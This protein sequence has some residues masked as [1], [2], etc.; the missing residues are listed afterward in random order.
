MLTAAVADAQT[1]GTKGDGK[2]FF[3]ETFGWENADD[4]KG[5]T[6]P[7][8]YF[9]LDPKDQGTNWQW[10][11]GPFVDLLTQDPALQSTTIENGCLALFMEPFNASSGNPEIKVDNS[12]VFP[13]LDCSDHSSVV[14]RYETHFMGSHPV[15][16]F[17]EVTVDDWV[18][19]ASYSVNFGCGH[20]DRP[21]DYPPGKAALMEVNISEIA[22]GMPNVQMR[23]HWMNSA[24]YYWAID[25]FTVSE[26]YD[27]DMKIGYLQM[28]WEEG[29]PDKNMAWIYNIPKSQLTGTNGFTNFQSAVLN[30]GEYDL[31]EVYMDLN[32]TKAGNSVFHRTSPPDD[33]FVLYTDTVRIEDLYSPV[34][35]GHYKVSVEFKSKFEDQNPSD[36]KRE[37]LFNVTDSIYSRADDTNELGWS[38]SKER[39]DTNADA[40]MGHFNGS[41]FPI[42]N[43][44]EV[45]SVSVF[46]AGGK[47]D[48]FINYRFS[49]YYVPLDEGD[50]TPF[51]ILTTETIQLD[52]ADFDTWVT[53]PFEKDGETEF[54]KQG[55]LVYAGITYDNTNPEPLV[56]RNRGLQIG[57]DNS[58]QLTESTAIAT[59]DGNWETG[60]GSFIGKK[61]LMIRLNLNDDSNIIDGIGAI[62]QLA[63]LGQNYPNPFSGNTRIDFELAG[64]AEVVVEV[65][66]ISGRQVMIL[67]KGLMPAG[68]HTID[69]DTGSLES[70]VYFYAMRA[71]SYIK[72]RRMVV[73]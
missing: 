38:F 55:D 18:R 24:Y 7:E 48:E 65:T 70:G 40:N 46:I 64:E 19:F 32:I 12:V 49:L 37:A 71:G 1:P 30:F 62:P 61:N 56:R 5:W 21:L 54:L 68:K 51:E 66:D 63:S 39:Y 31:E 53:L 73:R 69:L 16:M 52:S 3:T 33:L 57:T 23:L 42:F 15:D 50:P 36:N 35:F 6:A 17:L 29:N 45:N 34:D 8:G 13:I 72:T 44:C 47:A 20:K 2:V 67:N 28:E 4:P 26:A 27:H 25:D 60:L 43:D 59:Y 10:W 58:V 11:R 22:A 9:F 14:V 41:I